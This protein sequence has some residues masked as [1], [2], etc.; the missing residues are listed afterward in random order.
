MIHLITFFY[1]LKKVD[2]HKKTR[3]SSAV[4]REG[5]IK[6]D[7]IMKPYFQPLDW[8]SLLQL[9]GILPFNDDDDETRPLMCVCTGASL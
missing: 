5:Q 1:R 4:M 2:D 7:P 3:K 9:P 8:K 6:N